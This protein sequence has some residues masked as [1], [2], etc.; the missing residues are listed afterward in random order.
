MLVSMAASAADFCVPAVLIFG[1][2]GVV[3][4]LLAKGGGSGKHRG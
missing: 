4:L 1:V 2:V 3:L